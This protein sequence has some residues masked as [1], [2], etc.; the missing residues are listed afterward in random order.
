MSNLWAR[1][2][3]ADVGA[4]HALFMSDD[5]RMIKYL[6]DPTQQTDGFFALSP[7][8]ES[9]L[10][11]F[12]AGLLGVGRAAITLSGHKM[13]NYAAKL[14]PDEAASALCGQPYFVDDGIQF[15]AGMLL[16]AQCAAFIGTQL[17]NIDSVI[18]ELMSA[19]RHPAAYYDIFNDIHRSY[20]SDENT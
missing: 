9:C 2:I 5:K 12:T 16:M 18:V 14:G 13:Q 11:S 8:P 17:S 3:A 10:P 1:R 15:F 20:T 6:T 7:A 19:L 4:E